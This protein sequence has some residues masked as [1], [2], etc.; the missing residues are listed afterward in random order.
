[1]MVLDGDILRFL[2]KAL[3]S[4]GQFINIHLFLILDTK[5]LNLLDTLISGI[6]L[7]VF[8]IKLV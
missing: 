6:S 4:I 2:Q 8:L 1:M 3:G 7:I 5:Q